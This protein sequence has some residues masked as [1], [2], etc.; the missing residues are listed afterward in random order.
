M[1][2]AAHASVDREESEAGRD[3]T[4]RRLGRVAGAAL[5][6]GL[7]AGGG[8]L[9]C[10]VLMLGAACGGDAPAGGFAPIERL[11]EWLLPV[12]MFATPALLVVA[13]VA[14]VAGLL[15]RPRAEPE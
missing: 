3:R 6:G 7:L 11:A 2:Q 14:W 9:F 5:A 8:G 15:L 4:G 1:R 13:L 10:F 12:A